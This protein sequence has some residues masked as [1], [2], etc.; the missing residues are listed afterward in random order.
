MKLTI[1]QTSD[2]HGYLYPHNYINDVN[3]GL[4][5]FEAYIKKLKSEGDVLLIDTGDV[6][7]GSPLTY[8]LNKFKD[9]EIHPIINELNKFS[10][11]VFTPGNHE[12]NY[13]IE[14]LSASLSDFNGQILNA[15]IDGLDLVCKSKPYKIFNYDGFKICVFG[16]TTSHVPNWEEASNI[17]GLTFNSIIE[18]YKK[19]EDEIKSLSDMII[20][21]YHGGFEYDLDNLD[22]E[23]EVIT[24]END[25][26]LLLKTFDSIDILLTGHQ[27]RE[28]NK[29]I[30]DTLCMQP[31]CNGNN[32][33]KIDIVDGKIIDHELVI[34]NEYK[35]TPTEI[36]EISENNT[37]NFL[38]QVIGTST[39]KMLI[40]DLF[41]AR[42][43]SHPLVNFLHQ[44]QLELTNADVSAVSL[45][46]SAI[47]FDLDISVRDIVAN[48]PFP[49]T[50]KV[51]S[52][53]LDALK[54]A[55]EVS[56]EYFEIINGVITTSDKFTKPKPQHFNYDM[57]GGVNYTIDITKPV[58]S[59]VTIKSFINDVDL[60]NIK[61]VINN[62]RAANF[63]WYPMYEGC[64][65]IYDLNMDM[66]ELLINYI[67]EHKNIDVSLES[68]YNVI[69]K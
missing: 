52:V 27:H 18:T 49:N 47:G 42:I 60:N 62:Y 63:S 64:E 40:D 4:L 17:E 48:Y 12:F 8:Y 46:D 5:R 32:L 36:L 56:A 57:F 26:G 15:N 10:Y 59:R 11:D 25:G 41:D 54:Q 43:N 14:Y 66:V 58:G 23:T 34:I 55:M 68:F 31:G 53:N 51:L 28:I 1:I 30:N 29:I 3:C 45:F 61:I 65:V 19:Y 67:S 20:V 2:I 6:I 39:N 44:V 21:N 9:Y 7:Q 69:T 33:S 38:D 24:H 35:I 37:Q 13:G 16:L 22:V 50:L